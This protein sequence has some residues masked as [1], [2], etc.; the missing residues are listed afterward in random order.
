[1][2]DVPAGFPS[3]GDAETWLGNAWRGLAAAGVASVVLVQE[4]REVTR[5]V[6]GKV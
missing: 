3:R 4:G 1:M 5:L 2:S 6:L